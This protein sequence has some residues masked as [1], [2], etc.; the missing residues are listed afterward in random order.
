MQPKASMVVPCYN[1]EKDI[2]NMLQSVLGQLWD[3]IEVILVNDGSTDHTRE[4]INEWEPILKNRGYSVIIID[5]KN[6]G[7]CVAAYAGLKKITGDY[8]CLVDCDD[9]LLPGYVSNMVSWLEANPGYEW[10][11]CHYLYRGYGDER[12]E[13]QRGPTYWTSAE[14]DNRIENFLFRRYPI[15][16]WLYMVRTRYLRESKLIEYFQILKGI[17]VSQEPCFG[18]PLAFGKGKFHAV[19][20]AL[21][22]YNKAS[23]EHGLPKN[24]KTASLLMDR[25]RKLSKAAIWHLPADNESKSRLSAIA[26]LSRLEMLFWYAQ[27]Y[28][29]MEARCAQLAKEAAYFINRRFS[30]S[31]NITPEQILH[32]GPRVF[33]H[34]VANAALGHCNP[35][36]KEDVRPGPGRVIGA[37]VFGVIGDELIRPLLATPLAPDILWDRRAAPGQRKEGVPVT[38]PAADSLAEDDILLVFPRGLEKDQNP[39]PVPAGSRVKTIFYYFDLLEYLAAKCFPQLR[40]QGTGCVE[41]VGYIFVLDSDNFV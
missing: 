39:Y 11:G 22:I 25:Y 29:K 35:Y 1:K 34:A 12:A 2:A 20:D 3:N 33:F 36:F 8:F 15:S 37:G 30:P 27:K 18:I 16:S 41:G 26:E 23:S 32:S 10:T 7:P 31:P 5:Q 40:G 38:V 14:T 24:Y 9:E 6:S 21:Y 13:L 4:I 17:N 19:S 28:P